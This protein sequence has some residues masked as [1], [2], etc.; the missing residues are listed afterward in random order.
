MVFLLALLFGQTLSFRTPV[1]ETLVIDFQNSMKFIHKMQKFIL[2][3]FDSDQA[4]EL[5]NT[6][7]LILIH[8]R[9][10]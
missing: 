4:A 6:S 7:V 10:R 3:L 5:V 8:H 1:F 2:I 9:Q